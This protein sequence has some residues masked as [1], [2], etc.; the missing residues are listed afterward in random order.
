MFWCL[1]IN[2]YGWP[3]PRRQG[4]LAI[5]TQCATLDLTPPSCTIPSTTT[6][7]RH[8]MR[9]FLAALLA[10]TFNVSA[11]G[12]QSKE[13][14]LAAL[15]AQAAALLAEIEAERESEADA[16]PAVSQECSHNNIETC[17]AETLCTRATTGS[18]ST[19]RTNGVW[20][21]YSDE[22]KRRGLTCGVVE[23]S[24]SNSS[25]LM[26][27][28]SPA[29][30]G[31]CNSQELCIRGAYGEPKKW[32]EW[33]NLRHYADEAKRRGLACGVT[34]LS[35]DL[36][37]HAQQELEN[38]RVNLV[39]STALANT[40]VVEE[41]RLVNAQE[42]FVAAL[43]EFEKA[44]ETSS[45]AFVT[46]TCS[47]TNIE[48]CTLQEICERATVGDPKRWQTIG[49]AGSYANEAKRLALAC[50]VPTCATNA[51]LCTDTEVCRAATWSTPTRWYTSGASMD[52]V[53]EAQ[54]RGLTCGVGA[55]TTSTTGNTSTD[56]LCSL[57]NVQ[58]CSTEELCER[59]T[60]GTPLRWYERSSSYVYADEAKR[61]GL[62]CGVGERTVIMSSTSTSEQ[63]SPTNPGACNTQELCSR[64]TV[65]TPKVWLTVG[66]GARYTNE[67]RRRGLSCGV[68]EQTASTIISSSS[69][70]NLC[71]LNNV[72]ACSTEQLCE[73]GTFGTPLRW[74]ERSSS[75]VYADEA[76]RRGLTCGVG[77]RATTTI[78]NSSSENSQCSSANPRA[79]TVQRLCTVATYG[80]PKRWFAGGTGLGFA[81]EAKRRG[82]TCGV[83][84]RA[85]TTSNQCSLN[86][87][88]A[89]ST[90]LVCARGTYGTPKQWRTS[91]SWAPYADEAKRRGLTCGVGERATT[92]TQSSSSSSNQ[93][94][95][96]NARA[97][98]VQQLCERATYGSPKRWFASGYSARY[99]DEARR[100]GLSCDVR[101]AATSNTAVSTVTNS[102][103]SSANPRACTLQQLCRR[104]TYGD[105]KR[106]FTSGTAVSFSNEAKRRGLTCGVGVGTST[107]APQSSN[108][109]TSSSVASSS[110]SS[111]A[112]SSS[113]SS[114]F[115]SSSSSSDQCAPTNT[116]ACTISQL[117]DRA[118]SGYPKRWL[119]NS[120]AERAE[121]R[122]LDCDVPDEP[123]EPRGLFGNMFRSG[124]SYTI[125]GDTIRL[126]DGTRYRTSGNTIWGS[127]GTSYRTSGG[128]LWGSDGINYR[129]SGDTIWGSDGTHY[130]RTGDTIWT[131]DGTMCRQIGSAMRCF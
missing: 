80:D 89:C 103:C 128:N 74:Y 77:E 7:V 88:R 86:N 27:Q 61:R 30:P 117:C 4:R 104:A 14:Q 81:N 33:G 106:W 66:Y 125:S 85:A 8:T 72:R 25:G 73:R 56:L 53:R 79:C 51:N 87:V 96:T 110:S 34:T 64:A 121:A 93:C 65:G 3:G 1:Y 41:G 126:D 44:V 83:G 40:G 131:S 120:Y 119:E 67:A 11:F 35:V 36:V 109:S 29:D 84:E 6:T 54:R 60:F 49:I 10:V 71:S 123:D 16:Q 39:A 42:A 102:Q 46:L 52:Y 59:G 57:N 63:C 124:T 17:D 127:D 12:Q 21:E 114:S 130:R 75:Y 98:T 118:T 2:P 22:A 99:A 97:C 45:D 107:A 129:S 122:M 62:T 50:D 28:C 69:S 32:H 19:W 13:E 58:S 91:V 95:S 101:S 105:P 100:R 37:S 26:K 68:V 94:S 82:L 112:S 92:T 9:F 90:A 15:L 18:P 43:V 48:K 47:L 70:S 24:T 23:R 108:F 78:A 76:K 116:R 38:A 31:S 5:A 115:A 55:Q 113:S 20:R 111:F